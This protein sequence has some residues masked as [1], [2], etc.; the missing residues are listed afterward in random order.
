MKKHII[1]IPMAHICRNIESKFS[2]RAHDIKDMLWQA[3]IKQKVPKTDIY[4]IAYLWSKYF[5][6]AVIQTLTFY[7]LDCTAAY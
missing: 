3:N 7:T 2:K 4:D 6:K 1:C 5:V